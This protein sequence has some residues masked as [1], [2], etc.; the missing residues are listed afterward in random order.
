MTAGGGPSKSG[1]GGLPLPITPWS[2]IGVLGGRGGGSILPVGTFGGGAVGAVGLGISP[3][4]TIAI[5]SA[6]DALR[7]WFGVGLW[8]MSRSLSGPETLPEDVFGEWRDCFS[9]EERG[10]G[11]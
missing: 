10:E 5:L 8:T 1:Y 6:P 4:F 7:Y 9:A 2:R 3:E 11:W